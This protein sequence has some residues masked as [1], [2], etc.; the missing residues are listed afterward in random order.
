MQPNLASNFNIQVIMKYNFV[1]MLSLKYIT[2]IF[3]CYISASPVVIVKVKD[4]DDL[5]VLR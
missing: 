2:V 1:P 5:T 4:I 3:E